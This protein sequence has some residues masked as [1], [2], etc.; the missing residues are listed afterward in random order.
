MTTRH[1]HHRSEKQQRQ[2]GEYAL[3][4][5]E[6]TRYRSTSRR[7]LAP[8]PNH[9]KGRSASRS[10]E[11]HKLPQARNNSLESK[12]TSKTSGKNR[13]SRA[14]AG[15]KATRVTPIPTKQ[16]SC[17]TPTSHDAINFTA[18]APAHHHFSLS[19]TQLEFHRWT[20]GATFMT[21]RATPTDRS[22]GETANPRPL[23]IKHQPRTI[24]EAAR[25]GR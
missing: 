2:H 25:C 8:Q 19:L 20:I 7:H 16:A 17:D 11:D 14:E 10:L 13:R 24:I 3:Q 21:R 23:L 4:Q 1:Q 15:G 5:P 12:G 9:N 6:G 18:L 22:S